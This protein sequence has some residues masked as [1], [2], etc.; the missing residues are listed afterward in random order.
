M[1]QNHNRRFQFDFDV[2]VFEKAGPEG[3]DRRIGGIVSTDHLDRQSEVLLQEGLDFTPFLKGGWFNDN[4]EST[5]D[6][7]IGYPSAAELR[8]LPDGRKGWY[9]EGFLLKTDRANRIWDLA[10]EL[11][12]SGSGRKLGFSVEGSIAERDPDDPKKVRK[13]VVR[14]VAITKCPV[15][16]HTSLS[17]LAK[18]L[19]VGTNPPP[20]GPTTDASVL[21]PEALEGVKPSRPSAKDSK[22]KRKVKQRMNKSEAVDFLL[23][24]RPGMTRTL[25]ERVVEYA[26]RWHPAA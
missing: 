25:A 21:A 7:V 16:T 3:T 26:I 22:K 18:S 15:N 2:E 12:R 20:S 5:T 11:Q 6:S 9:V 14:E 1:N 8:H 4:H 10:T 17:V 23:S 19:A 13:A 24:I